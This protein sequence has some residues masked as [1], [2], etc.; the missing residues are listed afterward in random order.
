MATTSFKKEFVVTNEEDAKR[1][2]DDLADKK[3][4]ITFS[5]TDMSSNKEKED[6][7]LARLV[8]A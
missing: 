7:L 3:A 4:T 5:R 6:K 8:S 2:Q 1:L